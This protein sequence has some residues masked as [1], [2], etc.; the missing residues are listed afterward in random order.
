MKKYILIVAS[1]LFAF[2][3][4]II[5]CDEDDLNLPDPITPEDQEVIAEGSEGDMKVARVFE[6]VS[7][8]GIGDAGSSKNAYL[9]DC[10][11]VT[12]DSL[13]AT[14]DFN[15]CADGRSGQ[16]IAAFSLEPGY[17]VIGLTAEIT[18]NSY[19]SDGCGISGTM[20]LEITRA[21]GADLGPTFSITVAEESKLIF[22]ESDATSSWWGNRTIK[23][24]EG[25][26]T[27]NDYTND[28]YSLEGISYGTTTEGVNYKVNI[29][30]PL[31]FDNQ[32]QWI[33]EGVVTYTNYLGTE[34][35]KNLTIDFS[36]DSSGESN[37]ECDSWI[38]ISDGSYKI[39]I[40][41]NQ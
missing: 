26:I 2:G 6:T 15:A 14:I 35:E 1:L 24:L 38:S 3:A 31:I 19:V 18:F 27:I 17:N 9:D 39:V 13:T 37:S 10:V 8:Y 32:C 11:V 16:I 29:S 4:L 25:F 22:I 7:Q 5:S 21:L 33:P 20:T 36:V 40:D 30:T 41:I 34:N 28:I 12:W 23:W